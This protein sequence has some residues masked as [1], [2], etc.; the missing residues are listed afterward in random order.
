MTYDVNPYTLIEQGISIFPTDP[1]DKRPVA[2]EPRQHP[3]NPKWDYPVARLSW[4][5]VAT[6]DPAQIEQWIKDYPGCRWGAPTGDI[7]GFFAVDIDSQAG[8]DWWDDKWFDPGSD[9]NSPSGGR[10]ARYGMDLGLDIQTNRGKIHPDVDIR[11]EGGYIVAYTD[12]FSDL[13]PAPEDL[14]EFLP[15]RTSTDA[16][17]ERAAEAA[18]VAA[19]THVATEVTPQEAR[20]LK[21]ITDRLDALPRP[22]RKGAGY[23]AVQFEAACHLWRI[24]NNTRD[25]ATTEAD[26]YALFM[27]HAPLRDKND[28]HLREA[29]WW[30]GKKYAEGQVADPPGETPIRL[31]NIDEI[32]TKYQD[33]ETERLFWESRNIGDVKRLIHNLRT[34]GADMQEAYSL[35]YESA[36]MKKMRERGMTQSTWGFV[37]SEYEAPVIED[38]E[39]FDEW[40]VKK[41]VKELDGPKRVDKPV[42]L[43]TEAERDIIRDYPNFIDRYI[44]AAKYLYAEPNL[45]LHYVNAWIALSMGIGDQASIYETKGRMP[46]SLWGFLLA[47]SAAGKSDAN[48]L[49]QSTVDALRAGGWASVSLGDD[50]SAE[51][52]MDIVVERPGKSMGIF[53]DECRE[54]LDGSKRPGSY[55]SKA[56]G[57]YLKLYD[58]KAKRQLRRGMDKEQVGEESEVAFTLWMQGAWNPVVETMDTRHIENGFVGR[59]LVAVGGEAKVTRDSLTPEIASEYQVENGGRHP[60]IDSF[61]IPVRQLVKNAVADGTRIQFANRE[62]INRYVDMRQKLDDFAQSHPLAEHL[63]GVLLRVGINM[64]KGAALL[65]LSEGRLHI[66]MQD[67]LLAMKSGE[68]WVKGS[69]ELA[70]AISA[71]NYRRLVEHVVDL[72]QSRSRSAAT[73]YRSP[74]FQNMKR[75]EVD[76]IVERAE[77]EG[78]IRLVQGVWEAV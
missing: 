44:D 52:L 57:A 43:L 60:M 75:F 26:A 7:N 29:R 10:H 27:K 39:A 68:Y 32:L 71:S 53:M 31:E 19:S 47:P 37:K 6:T 28:A 51:Q 69:V 65:A 78:K 74:R 42:L 70:E 30:E 22:W 20:V 45:P 18:E 38:D 24:V 56:L 59:F 46:L 61:A 16:E 5:E 34:A 21:G 54:F 55:E 67:M 66:E 3:V 15:K 62:V 76:E 4:G 13:P 14:I 23:H 36:A 64:F 8:S 41:T 49:L 58:G 33:S 63:R 1:G 77:K 48:D 25:Y 12:D 11:G 73:I 35:S 72:V 50:T 2:R 40:E 17:A 9:V